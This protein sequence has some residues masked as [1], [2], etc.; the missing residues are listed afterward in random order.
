[1]LT[2]STLFCDNDFLKRKKPAYHHGNLRA[3]LIDSGLQLIEETGIRGLTLR[4]IGTR[5]NVSRSAAYRHFKDKAALLDAIREAGFIEFGNAL[6]EAKASAGAGFDHQ[7]D[8][9][10]MAYVRF[11][12][13]HRA[14]FEVMFSQPPDPDCPPSEAGDRAFRILE[15]TIREGQSAGA[16]RPGDATLIARAVWAM[17]HGVSL[18]KLDTT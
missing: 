7:I 13:E 1:M 5:L 4:E 2:L 10:G 15:E 11:P 14:H 12:N 9:M 18:L 3:S 17:I 8:A 6:E 16:V